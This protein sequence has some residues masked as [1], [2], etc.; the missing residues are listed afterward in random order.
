MQDTELNLKIKQLEK[1]I[2]ELENINKTN[3][4]QINNLSVQKQQHSELY[5][6]LEI[7]FN[8]LQLSLEEVKDLNNKAD[9]K[10][11]NFEKEIR[12]LKNEIFINTTTIVECN[13]ELQDKKSK[14][15]KDATK[16]DD[17]EKAITKLSEDMKK[18]ILDYEILE[19]DIQYKENQIEKLT[20]DLQEIKKLSKSKMN[21]IKSMPISEQIKD[22]HLSRSVQILK[23]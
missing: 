14:I 15:E 5:D 10:S 13:R 1:D 20:N 7:E 11:A 4:E 17:L 21:D 3:Q 16:I 6:K 18:K 19:N 9:S 12:E 2:I 23:F 8:K 22:V